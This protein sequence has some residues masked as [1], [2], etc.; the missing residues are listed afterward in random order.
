[1]L[2]AILKNPPPPVAGGLPSHLIWLGA[3]S[4]KSLARFMVEAACSTAAG[5]ILP[6]CLCIAAN[7]YGLLSTNLSA[8]R[9]YGLRASVTRFRSKLL[10]NDRN[11]L[12]SSAGV[13]VSNSRSIPSSKSIMH[14][15]HSGCV[16]AKSFVFFAINVSAPNRYCI[17]LLRP[18]LAAG[19]PPPVA[20]DFTPNRRAS[21]ASVAGA[22][23]KTG[24]ASV[25][26]SR[27]EFWVCAARGDARPTKFFLV[28]R[29]YELRRLRVLRA[30]IFC[31]TTG[32]RW[33]AGSANLDTQQNPHHSLLVSRRYSWRRLIALVR[34]MLKAFGH[35]FH[36]RS[37]YL[38][39]WRMQ[40]RPNVE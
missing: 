9:S 38:S 18:I 7:K 30:T 33:S 17:E 20:G 3:R 22:I 11:S 8:F 31:R 13:S 14:R 6:I 34:R 12:L 37:L 21:Q 1:V 24:G 5:K 28:C 2:R 15:F 32:C 19:L 27:R 40:L 10:R 26:A 25:L 23:S 36:H 39:L 29:F 16:I 35:T 4:S